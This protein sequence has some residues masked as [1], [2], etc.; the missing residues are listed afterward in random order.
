MMVQDK[1]TGQWYDPEVKL[2][3][4]VAQSWFVALMKRL[5]SK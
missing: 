5:A 4:L 1:K 3:E 2:K